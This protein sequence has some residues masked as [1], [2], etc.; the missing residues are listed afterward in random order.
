MHDHSSNYQ[1]FNYCVVQVDLYN[2]IIFML[3]AYQVSNLHR[4][5]EILRKELVLKGQV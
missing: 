2:A 4:K 3:I 1:H 5:T